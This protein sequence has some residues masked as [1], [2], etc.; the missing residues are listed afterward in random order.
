MKKRKYIGI[1]AAAFALML[2]L[3]ACGTDN[4]AASPSPSATT[5]AVPTVSP[6]S[7]NSGDVTDPENSVDAG[8]DGDLGSR[9]EPEDKNSD[10]ETGNG[11]GS[12]TEG[13]AAD[14]DENG[15]KP[16]GEN[17]ARDDLGEAGDDLADAARNAG[18]RME[19]GIRDM[20]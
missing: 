3:A 14:P 17:S 15:T 10:R 16:N 6:D 20:T 18:R 11:A 9:H 13:S 8:D 1:L 5:S 2:A 4:T 12:T 19:N 7:E